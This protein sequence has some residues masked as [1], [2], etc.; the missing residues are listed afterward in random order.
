[1]VSFKRQYPQWL[2]PGRSDKDPSEKPL[3]VED[4]HYWIDSL[5]PL[6]WLTTFWRIRK[7]APD[8]IVLQW[9]TSFWA[10]FLWTMGGLIHSFLDKPIAIICHNVLPHEA[11]WYDLLLARIALLRGNRFIVQSE[12]ERDLLLSLRPDAAVTPMPLP[13]F[14]LFAS[15]RISKLEARRELGLPLDV[16]TLLFFGIVREYKGLEDL[17]AALPKVR[18][19]LGI[20]KLI[21]AGEFWED[22]RAYVEMIDRLDLA[23][24]VIVEDRYIPNE[25][26]GL[27]FSAAD[28]VVAPYRRVTGSAAAQLAHGFGVPV[29]TTWMG[30]Q[31]QPGAEDPTALV[32]SPGNVRSLETAILGFFEGDRHPTI[33][34]DTGSEQRESHWDALIQV[35]EETTV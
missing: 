22:K 30:G 29:I 25:E 23:G 12:R 16:P 19:Q 27:Y 5:N 20:V 32:A 4:T 7:H 10:P 28:L 24:S 31:T 6:T 18:E 8:L 35:I 3:E 14:D 26:V 21:V 11:H 9:W 1:M 2:F 13:V 34:E 17:L 15:Q 33:P